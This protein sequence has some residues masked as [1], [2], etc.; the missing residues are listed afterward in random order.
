MTFTENIEDLY[1]TGNELKN[2][3]R[4]KKIL[5]LL[6]QAQ[7]LSSGEIAKRIG[8]SLPTAISLLKEL[9]TDEFV[10]LRGSGKSKGGRRPALFGLKNDSIFV[11]ACE[12]GRFTGKIGL[13]DSHNQL[14]AP[15]IEFQ[16]H[17]DDDN[18]ADKIYRYSCQIIEECKINE[19]RILGVGLAMPGLI[20]SE[21]GINYTIEKQSYRNIQQ[22]LEEKFQK[23]VYVN[24]DARMQAYGEFVFGSA[25]GY[26]NSLIINWNWGVGL[27]MILNGK[28]YNGSNGFAGE[29]SHIKFV[30][31]GELCICGK[32]GCLETETSISVLLRRAKRAIAEGKVSQLTK[33]FADNPDA[34]TTEDIIRAAKSGDEFTISLFN[35]L[36]T[37]LGKSLANTI[38]MLNPNII[39]L[40]GVISGA[41]QFVL[42]PIQQAINKY[43]LE[44]I[45]G[46]T[47]TVIS[48]E[49]E[50]SGMLGVTAMLFEKLFS[51]K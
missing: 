44:Q 6:Y 8:V 41:N 39:V 33:K 43:C 51:N 42:S 22:R 20:D 27:G 49:W 50:Q 12:L 14:V 30:E 24:N 2:Y 17:I 7:T 23:L 3:R 1:L 25:K 11:F 36:G 34:L 38:Q 15:V 32:R 13:Y 37:A 4:K 40:G 29:L 45:S 35:A 28:L 16:T 48:K 18:L 9:S 47:K 5:N 46:I 21:N 19:E 31:D 10:E 26:K